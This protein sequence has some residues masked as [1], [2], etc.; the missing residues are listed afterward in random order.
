MPNETT[1]SKD[2]VPVVRMLK[3][4][5]EL[6]AHLLSAH[7]TGK[8]KRVGQ[9]AAATIARTKTFLPALREK[10]HQVKPTIQPRMY[11]GDTVNKGEKNRVSCRDGRRRKNKVSMCCW[12]SRMHRGMQLP[13]LRKYFSNWGGVSATL[14]TGRKRRRETISS[15]KRKRG[16]EFTASQNDPVTSGPWRLLETLCLVV[17]KELLV[18][19]E[20][21]R[22]SL[23]FSN[24]Y[25][26]IAESDKVKELSLTIAR[27]TT[28]QVAAKIAHLS[29]QNNYWAT[30]LNFKFL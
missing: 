30:I 1:V 18:I 28:A 21:P 17:C 29:E 26:V 11:C 25:N 13:Q 19:N 7:V 9:N 14:S 22:S 5:L 2:D 16:S 24:L 12:R 6:L 23:N 4:L 10:D 27:K 8:V 20:L 3:T 15:Y